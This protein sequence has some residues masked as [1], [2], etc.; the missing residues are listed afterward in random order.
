MGNPAL[1]GFTTEELEAEVALRDAEA[2]ALE[3]TEVQ[4]EIEAAIGSPSKRWQIK[5]LLPNGNTELIGDVYESHVIDAAA[6]VL[7]RNPSIPGVILKPLT[8]ITVQADTTFVVTGSKKVYVE[9]SAEVTNA[10]N[11]HESSIL[12]DGLQ[13]W[14]ESVAPVNT[15]PTYG[16]RAS[17]GIGINATLVNIPT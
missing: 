2:R 14:M 6:L 7:S 4:A 10:L 17:G 15:Q 12:A 3:V 8:P 13:A 9:F 11:Q 16:D 1:E 5:K